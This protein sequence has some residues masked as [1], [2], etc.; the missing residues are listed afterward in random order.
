MFQ[1]H[2]GE[3]DTAVHGKPTYAGMAAFLN[4]RGALSA[5]GAEWSAQ[6]LFLAGQRYQVNLLSCI[7]AGIC[8]WIKPL[9]GREEVTEANRERVRANYEVIRAQMIDWARR[10]TLRLVPSPGSLAK[11]LN[12]VE[13]TTV[14][15][16]QWT[17]TAVQNAL[18]HL[19][20]DGQTKVLLEATGWV[21]GQ[22]RTKEELE[23]YETELR[24][25][26]M[27]P[28]Y[29]KI[30]REGLDH[31]SQ[32]PLQLS[33]VKNFEGLGEEEAV[34]KYTVVSWDTLEAVALSGD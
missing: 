1:E 13:S 6:T 26:A 4:E 21:L 15:G 16:K 2:L 29:D 18:V 9:G 28:R 34:L 14:T 17:H 23:A 8:P 22:G 5:R 30:V 3:W 32:L 33:L 19:G 31:S 24:R 7:P 27:R 20:Y 12:K 10:Y 11:D 25:E